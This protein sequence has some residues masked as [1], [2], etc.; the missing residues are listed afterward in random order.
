LLKLQADDHEAD[1]RREEGLRVLLPE[2]T[3]EQERDHVL[4]PTPPE[5]GGKPEN[6]DC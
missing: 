2:L 5:E 6:E 4:K 1:K 3:S